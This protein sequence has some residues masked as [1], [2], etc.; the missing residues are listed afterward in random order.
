LLL[1]VCLEKARLHFLLEK[2]KRYVYVTQT[3]PVTF[4]A[5]VTSRDAESKNQ[6]RLGVVL[7]MNDVTALTAAVG[8]VVSLGSYDGRGAWQQQEC[9]VRALKDDTMHLSLVD[10]SGFTKKEKKPKGLHPNSC[11]RGAKNLEMYATFKLAEMEFKLQETGII[12][13]LTACG[14][15][16]FGNHADQTR[17]EE[18][19]FSIP[20]KHLKTRRVRPLVNSV[21]I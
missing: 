2:A 21:S 19:A 17:I 7:H 20:M 9:Y 1:P 6:D 5:K 4:V 15:K 8:G 16:W 12:D 13:S 14:W 3:G 10:R 11:L 18:S